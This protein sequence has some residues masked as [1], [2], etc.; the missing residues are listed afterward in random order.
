MIYMQ[1]MSALKLCLLKFYPID[2][3]RNLAKS[4]CTSP[5]S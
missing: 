5:H 3:H 1:D 2:N 4:R